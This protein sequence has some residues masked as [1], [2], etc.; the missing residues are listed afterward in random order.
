MTCFYFILST[1]RSGCTTLC[2]RLF[3]SIE[4]RFLPIRSWAGVGKASNEAFPYFNRLGMDLVFFNL[5]FFFS[6][7][8]VWTAVSARPF[9]WGYVG[10]L[11]T[12]LKSHLWRTEQ[13][14][15]RRIGV[16]VGH[17]FLRDA[18]SCEDDFYLVDYC[19]ASCGGH[20]FQF[21]IFTVVVSYNQIMLIFKFKQISTGR[22]ISSCAIIG[23]LGLEFWVQCRLDNLRH[24]LSDCLCWTKT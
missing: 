9:D 7:S 11:V 19:R 24:L 3:R 13:I 2:Q 16:V 15:V 20:A 10:L 21:K 18:T 4:R 17:H 5:A 8:A 23:C 1:T 12:W 6:C 14:T 22:S